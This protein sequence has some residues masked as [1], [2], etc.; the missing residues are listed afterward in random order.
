M[1]TN[2]FELYTGGIYSEKS[3]LPRQNHAISVVGWG[4]DKPS[5]T[6]YWIVR[7]SWGT[8]FGENGFFRIKMHS[9]N[10]GIDSSPCY[11]AVPSTSPSADELAFQ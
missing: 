6:E 3:F 5:N 10:L 4:L 11:W 8:H 2:K 7:N 1:V 9:D